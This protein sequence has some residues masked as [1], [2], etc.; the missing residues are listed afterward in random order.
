MVETTQFCESL[1]D[2]HLTVDVRT[3]LEYGEDH[4]PGAVNVPLLSNEERIVIGIIHKKDGPLAARQRGLELTS[5]R[6]PAIVTAIVDH[7]D[8]RPVL[9][10]CWRG[11]LRSKTVTAILEL[12]GHRAIQLTG[13]YKAY[14]NRVATYF[15][16][17]QP[18]GPLIVLHGLTGV[19]KTTLLHQL[20]ERGHAAVDLEGLARHRGSAFGSLG[21][22]QSLDQKKFESL[23]WQAF[24]I[25]PAGQ[26]IIIEGESRRIGALS[27]PGNLYE[28]MRE[29]IKIWCD[30]SLETR[31]ARL[32][33]EY[34]KEEYREGMAAALGRIS[35]KLGSTTN[36]EL[37]EHLERWNLGPFMAGLLKNYYDRVYYKT[38]SWQEDR[39]ISLESFPSAVAELEK[40]IHEQQSGHSACHS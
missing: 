39:Q 3:P 21:L 2:T 37:T 26:P 18:P 28:V 4:I 8:G 1:L 29:G 12:T 24:R 27:L 7:A 16:P 31:V 13:G 35:K 33:T 20:A 11:G 38:R 15:S 22:N 14:R 36:R 34:G 19:G 9:V 25:C 32:I 5:G 6:F 40:F 10:Y 23:L 17:F 30:A